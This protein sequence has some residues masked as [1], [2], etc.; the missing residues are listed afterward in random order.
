MYHPTPITPGITKASR[1]LGIGSVGVVASQYSARPNRNNAVAPT[2]HSAIEIS[3]RSALRAIDRPAP[4]SIPKER[5]K[6]CGPKSHPR[7][8][9]TSE[10]DFCFQS[11]P[12]IV[13]NVLREVYYLRGLPRLH[14]FRHRIG[15]MAARIGVA[16]P[17]AVESPGSVWTSSSTDGFPLRVLHPYS[18][19]RMATHSRCKTYA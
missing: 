19:D 7:N 2:I 9:L 17:N 12:E 13:P 3:R 14:V 10:L 6:I 15:V 11:I 16:Q 1:T 8:T 18:R 5:S 4:T